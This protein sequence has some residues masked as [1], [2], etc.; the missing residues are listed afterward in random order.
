MKERNSKLHQ[1]F[2]NLLCK[3]FV[4]MW[5][6]YEKVSNFLDIFFE[7]R[8]TILLGNVVK[9]FFSP[10]ATASCTT[11]MFLSEL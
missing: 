4:K 6:K 8:Y 5:G 1:L 10:P 3:S 11:M 2:C 7:L 9:R